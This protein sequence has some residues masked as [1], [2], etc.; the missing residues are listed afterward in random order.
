[1]GRAESTQSLCLPYSR[2]TTSGI[3]QS[4][5]SSSSHNES[6]GFA[7]ATTSMEGQPSTL[8]ST[9]YPR[10]KEFTS[11]AVQP[12]WAETK[13]FK[14]LPTPKTIPPSRYLT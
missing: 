2:T 13:I 12:L 5:P 6:V 9:A 3:N 4:D 10:K 14:K 11:F 7:H 1:M 8:R